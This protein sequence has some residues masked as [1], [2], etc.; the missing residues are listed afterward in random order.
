[1]ND[2][3]CAVITGSG[4]A[5]AVIRVSGPEA[6]QCALKLTKS[7]NGPEVNRVYHQKLFDG[8]FLLDKALVTY[9]KAPKSFT[10]GDT[11]EFACHASNYIKGRLLQILSD[12]GVRP[13]KNG[14]FSMRA[15]INGK[16]DLVEANGLCDLIASDNAASHGAAMNSMEGKLSAEFKRI[17]NSLSEL[18]AQIEVRIDDVDEEMQ[19]LDPGYTKKILNDVK[20]RAGDLASTFSTGKFVKEGIKVAI[21]GVPN[22]GKSSLLNAIVGFDR[23]IVSE[24]SGT[25]RDT[26][27]EIADFKGH[28][29]ILT[30][31][32]GI[33]E[34]ALDVAEREGMRRS[35]NAADKSDIIIFT[36]D[37]SKKHLQADHELWNSLKIKGK[38]I[39]LACNKKDIN[40]TPPEFLYEA[41]KVVNVSSKTGEGVEELKNS[42][43]SLLDA[44]DIKADSNLITS[45]VHYDMLVK[46]EKE[47]EEALKALKKDLGL[48]FL[49]EHVRRALLHLKEIIGEVYADDILG[50][51]FS[52]FCVGK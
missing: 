22:A 14:E 21:L 44:G 52:K 4:G 26:V 7:S 31:T 8:D 10:G 19:P 25:T 29:I 41:D 1:M 27:E 20:L 50:I 34:G 16:M 43:I 33:K 6:W 18:L 2:T 47:L 38:K 46:T 5:V 48:E 51:I 39:I 15:F 42:V 12:M 11:V 28:K 37:T 17:K 24:H 35:L 3:I 30:D 9:F 36:A 40:F 32:A 45:A 23:A 13:A 49:A